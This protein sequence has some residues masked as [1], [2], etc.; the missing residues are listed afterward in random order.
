MHPRTMA[1]VSDNQDA[2]RL[3]GYVI[4]DD[5]KTVSGWK[6]D[7]L[8]AGRLA[9]PCSLMLVMLVAIV[10]VAL[11]MPLLP[12][13]VPYLAALQ[14]TFAVVGL[15]QLRRMLR[16][17]RRNVIEPL[18]QL[19]QWARVMRSGRLSARMPVPESGEFVE[20]AGDINRLGERLEALTHDMDERV[21]KQTTRL[22]HQT[23]SLAILYEVAASINKYRDLEDLLSHFLH[24]LRDVTDARAATVRLLGPD[25]RMRLIAS[26]GL[27]DEVVRAEQ[28]LS[29]E[30]SCVC[31]IAL[32][33]GS[34]QCRNDIQECNAII[35]QP[36]FGEEENITLLAVPLQYRGHDLGIYNLFLDEAGVAI[37]RDFTELLTSIGRHLGMAIE[38]AYLDQKANR[39]S[40]MQERAMLAHELHDSLAQTLASLRYQVRML[41]DTLQQDDVATA[42]HETGRIRA[43][44]DE[45]HTELR[46]LLFNFRAPLDGRGLVPALKE[47][48]EHFRK[49]TGIAAVLQHDFDGVTLP[50]L[51]EMQVIRIIQEALANS[52]KHSKAQHVRVLI[53]GEGE[54][55]FRVLIEDDGVGFGDGLL[56][57]S[58]GEHLGLSI[59]QERA[60]RLGGELRIESEPGE[61]TRIELTFHYDPDEFTAGLP[62]FAEAEDSD[63]RPHH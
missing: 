11:L 36:I 41:D 49:E 27:D 62:E 50:P 2:N 22:A 5:G 32:K 23:R 53:D 38:K 43:S 60:Q 57:G 42:R 6:F 17:M 12:S 28:H 54:G 30:E 1:T 45:A 46:Q 44:L 10:V 58:P 25:R 15:F 29:M 39:L 7:T 34:I 20:L 4:G 33:A 59:M 61:G 56:D 9:L 3:C 40:L 52:R 26:L 31:G 35:G 24:T 21:H 8:T 55:N 18:E 51:Q 13:A 48:V 47:L 14:L 19:R 37:S 63:A 16:R